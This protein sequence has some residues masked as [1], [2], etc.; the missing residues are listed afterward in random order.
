[1]ATIGGNLL[2]RT[3]CR[4]F[5]DPTVAACNK[6]TPGSGC[7]AVAGA[8]R[9]HAILGASEH[10]IALHAS[11]LC[12]PLVALDAVVRPPGRRRAAQ[13]PADRVLRRSRANGRT[14]RTCSSTAS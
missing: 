8:A 1:M 14:S 11:D 3:R 12:V 6:R 10:C 5:R 13:R 7:A 2:Q 4:Y 9:M